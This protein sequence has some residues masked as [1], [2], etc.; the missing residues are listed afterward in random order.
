MKRRTS[1]RTTTGVTLSLAS[2]DPPAPRPYVPAPP[3]PAELL[4]NARAVIACA[5]NCYHTPPNLGVIRGEAPRP[6]AERRDD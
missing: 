4:A 5:R 6:D 3:L 1:K 2:D